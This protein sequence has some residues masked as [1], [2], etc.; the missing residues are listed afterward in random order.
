ML[1]EVIVRPNRQF[2]FI[3]LCVFLNF[4]VTSAGETDKEIWEKAR[5]IHEE[6]IVID[7]HAH[8]MIH[9]YMT[10]HFLDLGNKT[11][12]SQTDFVTM[13]EGGVDAV[14][15]S[16][17]LAGDMGSDNTS[18]EI[19][20][21]IEVVREEIEKNSR[22]ASIAS[23][24]SDIK[25]IH[26]AGKR[27]VMFSIEYP[28]SLEGRPEKLELYYQKGIRL[29]TIAH[30]KIERIAESDTEDAGESG[31]SQY[32]KAVVAEMNRL[33]MLID[34][35]HCPDRL[36]RDI[37]KES[38]VPIVASHSVTRALHNIDRNIPD[39]ILEAIAAKGG[40]VCMTFYCGHLSKEYTEKVQEPRQIF[41]KERNRL[42]KELK[43]NPDEL[44]KKLLE[45]DK[46]IFPPGVD[47]E[48]LI[49]HIDHAVKVAGAD[50]VGLGSDFGGI[51]NPIGLETAAGYP[52][53]TYYLIKRGYKEEDIKKILGGN[54][55]RVF[56]RVHRFAKDQRT[57]E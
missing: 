7:A 40:V 51:H 37:L 17:P 4:S 20:D 54:L 49:D 48:M 53:I 39:D 31:L 19:M 56:E 35:T 24:P 38:E 8:P 16:L 55:L 33:G 34:V 26:D 44:N 13:K 29:I 12:R 15:L 46:K 36:Q 50:H 57:Q 11:G 30:G 5:K 10:S 32:G 45:L 28:G 14:F 6:A 1:K 27:A 47:I 9:L 23:T 25:K 43:D 22:L 42:R 3:I 2:F 41:N 18:K 52:L 21:D